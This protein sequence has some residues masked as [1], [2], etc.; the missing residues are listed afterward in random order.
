VD[1]TDVDLLGL[2]YDESAVP[3][4]D[5]VGVPEP[6]T[7]TLLVLGAAGVLVRRNRRVA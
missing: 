5:P 1:N 3:L 7:M 6:A 4:S 2:N